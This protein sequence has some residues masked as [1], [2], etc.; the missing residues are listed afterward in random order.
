[1]LKTDML[2]TFGHIFFGCQ[3]RILM[4]ETNLYS[5]GEDKRVIHNSHGRGTLQTQNTNFNAN[6]NTNT[7]TNANA[8]AKHTQTQTQTQMQTHTHTLTQI[9]HTRTQ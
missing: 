5:Y 8:N 2:K 3:L 6:A 4:H 1:M 9:Q 7:D